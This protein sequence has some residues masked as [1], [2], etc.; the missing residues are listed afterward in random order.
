M[1]DARMS[2]VMVNNNDMK[3][4]ANDLGI[5]LQR[6]FKVGENISLA[7]EMLYVTYAYVL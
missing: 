7:Y 2:G 1:A 4:P 3:G 6:K 5:D